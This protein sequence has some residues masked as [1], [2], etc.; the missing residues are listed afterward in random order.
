MRES[1]GGADVALE[2]SGAA[3]AVAQCVEMVRKGGRIAA[4]G[5]PME[6]ARIPMQRLV[7][8]E[9]D[10]VGVRAA[11]GEMPGAIQLVADGRIRLRELITH[12]FSLGDFADAYA[13]STSAA[14]AR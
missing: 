4:I 5:I 1:T 2:C 6:G 13:T 12:R 9:I 7:L 14:T 8:D 10:L 11:A 3:E